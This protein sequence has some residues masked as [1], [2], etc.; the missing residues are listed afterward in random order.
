VSYHHHKKEETLRFF[1]QIGDYKL[2]KD[3]IFSQN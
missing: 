1:D 3:G 2:L